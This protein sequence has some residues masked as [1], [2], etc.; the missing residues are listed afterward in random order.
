MEREVKETMT[1]SMGSSSEYFFMAKG[2]V[3]WGGGL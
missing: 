3:K 2:A 1:V